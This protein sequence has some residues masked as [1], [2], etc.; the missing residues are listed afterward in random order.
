M[1]LILVADVTDLGHK[2][3]V[4]DVADGYARNFLLP[5]KKAIAA[6]IGAV[7]VAEGLRTARLEAER[8]ALEK[9]EAVAANLAGTR[10]VIAAHAGDEGRL[11]GSIGVADLIAGIKKFTGFDLE[12]KAIHLPQPIRAIGLHEVDIKLHPSVEFTLTIDVVPA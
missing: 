8:K 9:A 3:D 10:V 1:K 4:V 11:Y 6:T 2:G 12:R 5:R 7:K